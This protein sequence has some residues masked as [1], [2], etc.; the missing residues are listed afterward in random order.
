MVL[1]VTFVDILVVLVLLVSA[2]YAAW[3]G[4]LSETLS[5]FAWAAAAFATLYFGPWL[6]PLMRGV[7]ATP[8]MASLAAYAGIFLV[9]LIP[10]SF[11]SHRFSETVKHSPIGP[12]DRA[13]GFAFGVVRGLVIVGLAYM[14]F[15]YFVPIRQQPSALTAARTL[16]MMQSTAEVLLSLAPSRDYADFA[17]QPGGRHDELGD[18]IRRNSEAN[19]APDAGET[20]DHVQHKS[21]SAAPDKKGYGAKDR[22][23]LDTLFE[24]TGNG[25][26]RKP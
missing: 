8:W 15:T 1:P 13:L 9:V 23:A 24:A 22:R 18:L 6:I 3:R 11:I 14:A 7:I 26:N 21:I 12:L 5:I 4:F 25:G 2:A 17:T 19:K 10:L 20:G 16:P